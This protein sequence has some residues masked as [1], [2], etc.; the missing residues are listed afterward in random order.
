M[1]K[2]VITGGAGFIGSHVAEK[3]VEVY[4]DA[5]IHILD[6]MTYAADFE[7]ISHLLKRGQRCL[8]VGDVCDFEFCLRVIKGSDLIL[9]L[10]AESHVDNSFGNSFRFTQSNTLGTHTLLEAARVSEVPK[11]IHVSTD[12]VY[13]EIPSGFHKETDILNPTNPYAASKAAA[14]MI[15]NSYIRSFDLPIISVRANNI[16]GIRQHPEKLIPRFTL[17]GLKGLKFTVHGDGSH[18]RRFLAAKDFAEALALLIGKGE[19]GQIYNIGSD[20]EYTTLQIVDMISARLGIAA[21][22]MTE[23][24]DDR[25]FNDCRYAIDCSK[26]LALGWKQRMSF[27]SHLSEVIEWY[28]HNMRRYE[29]MFEMTSSLASLSVGGV[30]GETIEV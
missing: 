20:S 26:M 21:S 3:M 25:P 14:D 13:G 18:S 10:A 24:V 27:E 12:E 2:I 29:H 5:E 6:K 22:T 11:F 23:F 9:H 4:P 28:K 7:N 15:V 16:Y 30:K 8:R 19:I 1:N 17:L